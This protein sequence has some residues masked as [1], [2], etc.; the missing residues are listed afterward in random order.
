[1]RNRLMNFIRTTPLA[2]RLRSLAGGADATTATGGAASH[3]DPAIAARLEQVVDHL[4]LLNRRMEELTGP[5]ERRTQQHAVFSDGVF[6]DTRDARLWFVWDDGDYLPL[7]PFYD[8]AA[9]HNRRRRDL[10]RTIAA[11]TARLQPDAL[12]FRGCSTSLIPYATLRDCRS[13]GRAPVFD[14]CKGHIESLLVD[15]MGPQM[16]VGARW[17]KP[18]VSSEAEAAFT[19]DAVTIAEYSTLTGLLSQMAESKLEAGHGLVLV[20]SFEADFGDYLVSGEALPAILEEAGRG[21]AL[22]LDLSSRAWVPV[23][24][25]DLGSLCVL[26]RAAS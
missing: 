24:K 21:R 9:L 7:H 5:V 17:A 26:M 13:L 14:D 12:A 4:L 6:L 19:C 15:Q 22:V 1:V 20:P 2:V 18:P 16:N 10:Y 23:A 25:A 11:M 8:R 3:S